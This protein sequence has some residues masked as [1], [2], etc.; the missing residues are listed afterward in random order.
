L[1]KDLDSP[2][3]FVIC[4]TRDGYTGPHDR[5]FR[6][7]GTKIAIDL[8]VSIGIPVFNIKRIDH[9]NTVV[10]YFNDDHLL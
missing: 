7:G 8:A 2:S 10:N 1:G 6:T 4:Y 9:H 5:S 3:E